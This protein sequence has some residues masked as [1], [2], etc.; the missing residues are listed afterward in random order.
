[1]GECYLLGPDIVIPPRSKLFRLAPMGLG[2]T[3]RECLGSYLMRLADAHCMAPQT[4]AREVLFPDKVS[5]PG[6]ELPA[7]NFDDAWRQ[8]Y[9]NGTGATWTE[10]VTRLEAATSQ[11]GLGDLTL[12]FLRGLASMRGLVCASPRWCPACFREGVPYARLMWSFQD[13][14]CCPVHQVRLVGECGCG[15]A[16]VRARGTVKSLPG[17]CL[18]CARDLGQAVP[19]DAPP[20]THMEIRRAR[21]IA[22]LLE[23]DLAMGRLVPNR[24]IADFLSDSITRHFEGNM[25]W[26][27]HRI[28]VNKSSMH[29]WVHGTHTPEFGQIITI[30]EAHGCSIEDVLCGRSEAMATSPYVPKSLRAGKAQARRRGKLDWDAIAPELEAMLQQDPPIHMAEVGERMGVSVGRLRQKHPAIC[31][32]I[33]GRWL[34]WRG[35]VASD[36]RQSVRELVHEV[37]EAMA[38]KGIQ[39][40]WRRIQEAGFPSDAL[41]RD[42]TALQAICKQV[43]WEFMMEKTG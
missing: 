10:W 43:W 20:P 24:G 32:A 33:S 34:E 22:D 11:G 17:I 21:M 4:L 15:S 42:R 39:P 26:L 9:F 8:P 5:T 6:H 14:T 28:G 37:A 23:G 41:M 1:M 40:S 7:R 25:A 38:S 31:A 35:S 12:G 16:D 13:V 18:N 19:S 2:T 3:H 29:G 30:A 36:R 27:G